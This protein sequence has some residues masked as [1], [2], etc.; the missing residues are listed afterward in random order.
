MESWQTAALSHPD[1]PEVILTADNLLQLYL[2]KPHEPYTFPKGLKASLSLTGLGV[3]YSNTNQ[4]NLKLFLS[5]SKKRK[6]L[7]VWD[8]RNMTCFVMNWCI[9]GKDQTISSDVVKVDHCAQWHHSHWGRLNKH[10]VLCNCVAH[11][12][13][14]ASNGT[15]PCCQPSPEL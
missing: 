5:Q 2:N 13:Q 8:C 9:K 11:V 12:E 6:H 10:I 15:Y 4:L 14:T 1:D 3:G 7:D